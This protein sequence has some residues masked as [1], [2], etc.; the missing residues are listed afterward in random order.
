M[1]QPDLLPLDD[2]LWSDSSSGLSRRDLLTR[3]PT[4]RQAQDYWIRVHRRA[5]ACRFE[6]TLAAADAANVPAAK[7]ALD[8]VDLL[9]GQLSVFRPDSA[10]CRINAHAAT[11]AVDV[12]ADVFGLLRRCR[13]LHIETEGA[14]D[15]TSTPLSRCWGFLQR[16]GRLPSS[17]EIDSARGR[18]GF[19]RVALNA[20]RQTVAFE[21]AGVELNLGAIGKGYALDRVSDGLRQSGVRDALLSAGRSSL[22]AI[23]GRDGGWQVELVA[24]SKDGDRTLARLWL[25]DAALGTSGAG[26]QFIEVDGVR[27]GH[28]I[29]PRTG[30]PASGVISASVIAPDASDAD[31]LSTAFLIGGAALAERYCAEHPG[32]VALL[33]PDDDSGRTRVFGHSTRALVRVNGP[34]AVQ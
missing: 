9:E 27:Y 5:M 7:A 10:L 25:R 30:W 15:I 6:I 29:D 17:A 14:F 24:P 19:A 34:A 16:D 1:L 26:E 4:R 12:D 8:A 21:T 2:A 28:V 33:T 32:V 31:A 13:E 18:V 20:S 22:L 23:G 3:L 11:R